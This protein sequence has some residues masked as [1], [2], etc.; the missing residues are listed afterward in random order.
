ML[1]GFYDTYSVGNTKYHSQVLGPPRIKR[2]AITRR[3]ETKH[4]FL[5]P[6]KNMKM[7]CGNF[8]SIA[9]R[10]ETEVPLYEGDRS[11]C[12][13]VWTVSR[14][15]FLLNIYCGPGSSVGIATDYRLDVR[16]RIPL[17][18]RFFARLH[19]PWGPPSLL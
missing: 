4:I 11:E 8:R 9:I 15:S 12:V 2:N 13:G 3:G 5:K 10:G 6:A 14:I 17:G 1:Y 18:T 16:D 7:S 19:R